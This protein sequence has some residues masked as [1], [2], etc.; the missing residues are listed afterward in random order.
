MVEA[1]GVPKIGAKVAF[2]SILAKKH[3]VQMNVETDATVGYVLRRL[4]N[5]AGVVYTLTALPGIVRS[6][7][8]PM[9]APFCFASRPTRWRLLMPGGFP[10]Q[11]VAQCMRLSAACSW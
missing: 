1:T 6:T 11:I 5:A 9:P 7:R 3:I 10:K 2:E 4:A 8:R